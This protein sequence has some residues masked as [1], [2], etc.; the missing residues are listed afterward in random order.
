MGGLE[1]AANERYGL[2]FE[3]LLSQ[4][5][6]GHNPCNRILFRGGKAWVFSQKDPNFNLIYS[7][8]FSY[9]ERKQLQLNIKSLYKLEIKVNAE[10]LK[11]FSSMWHSSFWLKMVVTWRLRLQSDLQQKNKCYCQINPKSYN[12][13]FFKHI[14]QRLLF[15]PVKTI[16]I[17][18]QNLCKVGTNSSSLL[19]YMHACKSAL[20][21]LLS[22]QSPWHEIT[23]LPRLKNFFFFLELMGS[24]LIRLHMQR[25]ASSCH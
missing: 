5:P 10:D 22:A 21:S 2:S 23:T 3:Q 13:Y 18:K 11:K 1:G 4:I 7:K 15:F 25:E 19:A 9:F 17:Y 6:L 24:I 20:S 12:F 16:F 14:H 8:R